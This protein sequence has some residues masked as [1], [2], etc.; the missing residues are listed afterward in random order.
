ML[1]AKTRGDE[2][3]DNE[4]LEVM[5]E[6]GMMEEPKKE[7]PPKPEE[8]EKPQTTEEPPQEEKSEDLKPEEEKKDERKPREPKQ[9]PAWQH[10]IEKKKMQKEFEEEKSKLTASFTKELE[11]IK[12][13]IN[14][15]EKQGLSKSEIREEIDKDFEDLA[16]EY[17]VDKNF[18]GKLQKLIISKQ[19]P[20]LSDEI[21]EKI[22]KIDTWEKEQKQKQEDFEYEKGFSKKLLP[23]LKEKFPSLTEVEREAIQ[24]KLKDHYFDEKYIK[25]DIDEIYTIKQKEIDGL[26][27]SKNQKSGETG[28][29]G[30]TRGGNVIDYGNL[31]ED[32]YAKLSP[33]EQEKANEFLEKKQRGLR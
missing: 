33:E 3:P 15:F 22:S 29:R 19:S 8:V 9:I 23:I 25:L 17:N 1:E 18:L 10:E 30:V 5:K 24:E 31:T 27:S 32:Q 6:L 7:E 12:S 11:D 21:S 28:T 4:S 14:N 20:K 2:M 16:E 13:K 26:I